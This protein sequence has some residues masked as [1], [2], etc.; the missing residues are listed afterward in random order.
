[1]TPS[2]LLEEML[3]E[4][5]RRFFAAETPKRWAQEKTFVI[6]AITWP[7]RYLNDRGAKLPGT[8]YR[9]ILREI[10]ADIAGHMT[11]TKIRRMSA[12]LLHSVQEH[13]RHQGDRYYEETKSAKPVGKVAERAVQRLQVASPDDTTR[14]FAETHAA[15][16]QRHSIRR[17]APASKPAETQQELF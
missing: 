8:R 10:F 7:A 9:Q 12:Y 11:K 1:M 4:A 14:V 13:M 3:M 17:P 5:R 2:E 16:A 6:Q 15:L